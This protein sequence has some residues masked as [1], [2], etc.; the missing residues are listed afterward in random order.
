MT[1]AEQALIDYTRGAGHYPSHH[2]M[3]DQLFSFA[4]ARGVAPADM[5]ATA[6]KW[7]RT[8]WIREQPGGL[9][10][11]ITQEGHVHAEIIYPAP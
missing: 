9:V 6:Q 11:G 3:F 4:K 1:R 7:Q 5:E 8:V 2:M 10:F